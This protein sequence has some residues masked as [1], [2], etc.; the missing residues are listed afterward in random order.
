[1]DPMGLQGLQGLL[2]RVNYRVSSSDPV[3]IELNMP[4]GLQLFSLRYKTYW[5]LNKT[6]S[7]EPFLG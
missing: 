6:F 2:Y 3:D 1:M 5:R 4:Q 7:L